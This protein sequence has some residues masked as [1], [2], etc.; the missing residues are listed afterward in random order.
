MQDIASL[1]A[2]QTAY[3]EAERGERSWQ[4]RNLIEMHL[5]SELGAEAQEKSRAGTKGSPGQTKDVGLDFT[6]KVQESH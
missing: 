4:N 3:R 1:R 2:E 6:P 5:R